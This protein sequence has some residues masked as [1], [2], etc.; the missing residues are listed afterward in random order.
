MHNHS[1]LRRLAAVCLAAS[2]FV[3]VSFAVETHVWQQDEQ[4]EFGHGTIKNLSV[5]SDG[6]LT[7][8]PA[9]HEL[10]DAGIPY[11]WSVVQDSH[12][13][14]YCAGGAPTGSTAKVLAVTP[15]GKSTTFAELTALEVHALAIDTKDRVYAATSPDAKIYRISKAGQPELFFDPKAKYVWAMAF[16]HAGNLFV[17]TGDQGLIYK[18]TPDG[19]G[20]EFFNTEETHARSMIIDAAG[21]LIVG[22]EPGGYIMRISPQ[23]KSFVL[24]QTGKREV[25]AV[26]EHDGA[27]YAA[28]AGTKP[29][30][31]AG[32]SSPAAPASPTAPASTSSKI[33]VASQPAAP[34]GA[35]APHAASAPATNAS[36]G[37]EFYRIQADGFAQKLW[38]SAT[39]VI[40]AIA[41]DSK[42][43]PLL[44]TGNRGL[45]YR[46]DSSVLSTELLNAPPTQVTALVPGR[47]G[48]LYATTGNVGKLYSIGPEVEASGSVESDVLDAGSFTYWGKA[49]LLSG[50]RLGG[51]ELTTRSGNV[52][53]PQKNWS[54]W[55]KVDLNSTGGQVSSPPARFLQYRLTLKAGGSTGSPEINAV[56]IAYLPKNIAPEVKQIEI[57]P[58]N[59]R[60]SGS[61]MLL[62]RT[63][64]A[65]GSPNT[66]SLPPVGQ[67]RNQPAS[68]PTVSNAV[69][70]QYAKGYITA[71]WDAADEN[72][73]PLLYRVEIR[74]EGEKQ[75]HLIKD[76]ITETQLSFDGSAFADGS[77][78]IQVTASDSA[79][80][81]PKDALT[82]KLESEA[83]TIDNTPP[84]LKSSGVK[85]ESARR[86]IRLT[87]TDASSWISKAEYSLDGSEWTMMQ[88][89]N[90]VSDSQTL[91]YSLELPTLAPAE[92]H[93]LAVRV[94]D[95]VDN[96]TVQRYQVP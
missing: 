26:A 38:S 61:P 57:A 46:V 22:T 14:L 33:T 88:P 89:E 56:Q 78:R 19:T 5:R 85:G 86:S 79:A 96:V 87:A 12:G 37:S 67:K 25:T 90:K 13:T 43:F 27:F 17:A 21:D 24:F 30:Q 72:G 82:D 45:I 47:N 35:A 48:I 75:W 93:T 81:S 71:R 2:A 34:S 65:S 44:G 29:P 52:S 40:Y 16:D 10:A 49:H 11:L 20:S 73:D 54:D 9:F 8:A 3:S 63:V 94:F 70:L 66:L 92:Q 91:E 55:S 53:R 62:E 23:G 68:S 95:D 59:Y 64:L 4:T 18:V 41:F 76:Q 39:D 50:S 1:G 77:Y 83:F 7:L 74:G 80:N 15:Q 32:A 84:E 31:P 51:V 6:R 58:E 42:G 36:G 69:T 28:A 60:T